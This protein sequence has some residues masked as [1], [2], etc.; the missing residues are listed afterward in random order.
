[1]R[2][3]VGKAVI[4][5]ILTVVLVASASTAAIATDVKFPGAYSTTVDLGDGLFVRGLS[6]FHADGTLRS[7]NIMFFGGDMG[8]PF[9]PWLTNESYGVWKKTGPVSKRRISKTTESDKFR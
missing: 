7:T 2:H 9:G 8:F 3:A 5:M 1:M 4:V 6:V